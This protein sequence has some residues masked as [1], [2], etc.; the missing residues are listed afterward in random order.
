[1]HVHTSIML[2]ACAH[3]DHVT[4]LSANASF[5]SIIVLCATALAKRGTHQQSAHNLTAFPNALLTHVMRKAE[6]LMLWA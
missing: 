1:M 6:V 5:T 4:C 2:H 3:I